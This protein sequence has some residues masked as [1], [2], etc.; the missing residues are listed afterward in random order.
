MLDPVKP[1][2]TLEAAAGTVLSTRPGGVLWASA[3][4]TAAYLGTEEPESGG[5][6][7]VP[8]TS[9]TWLTLLKGSAR[10]TGI[11]SRE[12]IG[13]GTL[14]QALAEFHRLAL[15][16]ELPQSPVVSGR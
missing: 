10:I 11:S 13:R 1:E 4:D 14:F 8:L 5:T 12:V 6:G 16:A 15:G 9:D 7:L 3:K 2:E